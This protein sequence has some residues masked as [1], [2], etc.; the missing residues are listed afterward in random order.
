MYVPFFQEICPWKEEQNIMSQKGGKKEGMAKR[1]ETFIYSCQCIKTVGK[2]NSYLSHLNKSL[3]LSSVYLS[4]KWHLKYSPQLSH[5][6]DKNYVNSICENS[7]KKSQ[8][9][10]RTLDQLCH[11]VVNL[12]G[13]TFKTNKQSVFWSC[14]FLCHSYWWNAS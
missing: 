10:H 9:L 5:N 11:V 4:R 8:F 2:R 7:K 12:F 3:S 1:G 6:Y 14:I 13:N